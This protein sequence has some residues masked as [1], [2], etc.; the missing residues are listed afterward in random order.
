[1]ITMFECDMENE[2]LAMTGIIFLCPYSGCELYTSCP[3]A[4]RDKEGGAK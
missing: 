4:A 2:R 3:Y 1:M